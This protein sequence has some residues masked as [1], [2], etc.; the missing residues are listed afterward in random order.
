MHKTEAAGHIANMFVSEDVNIGRVPTELTPDMFNAFQMELVNI[1]I[2]NGAALLTPGTDTFVQCRDA[3]QAY[4]QQQLNNKGD[5]KVRAASSTATNLAAPGATIGAVTMAVGDPFLEKDHATGALRGIYIWNGAAVPA[6]RDPRAD[7]GAELK[8]GSLIVVTE[9]TYANWIFELFTDGPIVI[10]TTAL[11]F[12]LVWQNGIT[13]PQFDNSTKLATMEA[14]QRA[15]GN[16]SDFGSLS[17]NTTL[18]AADVGKIYEVASGTAFAVTIPAA[19][20]AVRNG[21]A[22]Y[23]RNDN[24][25]AVTIQRQGTDQI[26]V[27][28]G[29]LT[30][31]VLQRGDDVWLIKGGAGYW[32]C[33]GGTVKARHSD[34]DFGKLL[35]ANGYQKLPSGLIIQWGVVTGL[36]ANT[37]YTFT[38]PI[39][40]PNASLFGAV[41]LNQSAAVG[42]TAIATGLG[43]GAKTSYVY[44]VNSSTPPG[45]AIL[46]VGGW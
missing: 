34:G 38:F 45:G 31:V 3:I 18:T 36:S 23:F 4:V 26:H 24:V 35:S 7:D 21:S 11:D 12:Q 41:T 27:G 42:Q 43:A 28:T 32:Y 30:S 8:A 37:D 25:G 5:F 13:P 19:D 22:L 6:T 44:R 33:C 10:G 15:L 17:A 2:M 29:L 40:F 14:V 16:F 46:I 9:G 39:A 1:A 20:A